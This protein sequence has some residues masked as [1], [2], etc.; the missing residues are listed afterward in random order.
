MWFGLEVPWVARRD[1]V[2]G[3]GEWKGGREALEGQ[4][5]KW[6]ADRERLVLRQ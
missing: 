5:R 3:K 1:W 2:E 6:R 4:G